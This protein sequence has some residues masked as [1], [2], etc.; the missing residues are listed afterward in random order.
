MRKLFLAITLVLGLIQIQAQDLS[1]DFK[2]WYIGGVNLRI[3]KDATLKLN[4]LTSF[5]VAGYKLKFGQSG[6]AWKQ[7][8]NDQWSTEGGYAYNF[9]K[10]SEKTIIYHRAHLN[11][12]HRVK[13]GKLRMTNTVQGE[14]YFPQLQ[15][16]Q[17]RGVVTNKWSYYNRHWPLKISPYIKNQVFYYHG[18][19]EITYWIPQDELDPELIEASEEDEFVEQAPN[20]WHRYRFTAG[21]RMKLAKPLALSLFCIHQR[22]FNTGWAPYRELNVPNKSGTKIKRPFNNYSLIGLSLIY[23]LKLY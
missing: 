1:Q 15:K 21:V 10:G 4:H 6:I 13:I 19:R 23:T 20:G 9:I 18:G 5:D 16:F 11:A 8:L 12:S 14:Y 17:A 7:K 22:E 2:N 3:T